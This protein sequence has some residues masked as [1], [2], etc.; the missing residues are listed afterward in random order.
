MPLSS[1]D[2]SWSGSF[3]TMIFLN[4]SPILSILSCHEFGQ[5]YKIDKILESILQIL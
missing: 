1:K 4:E 2:G 3:T 5:D